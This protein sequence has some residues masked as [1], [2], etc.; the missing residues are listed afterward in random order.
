ME[1]VAGL[2]HDLREFVN[3]KLDETR[4]CYSLPF[5]KGI[6]IKGIEEEGPEH[7]GAFRGAVD[8]LVDSG[9]PVLAPL[10]GEVVEVV[11]SNDRFGPGPEFRDSL[12]Y[13]TILHGGGEYSQVAHLA[14]GSAKVHKGE[15]VDEGQVLAETGNSGRM[16]EPHLHVLFFRGDVRKPG[17]KGLKPRFKEEIPI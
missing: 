17:F 6:K 5:Q 9:T 14:K 13:I 8:F 11:D 3:P 7:K 4:N 16:T 2:L 1:Q 15:T 12:N 10:S